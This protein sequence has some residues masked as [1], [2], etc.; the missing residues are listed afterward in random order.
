MLLAN[1]ELAEVATPGAAEPPERLS[2]TM[3][4]AGLKMRLRPR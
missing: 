1:F 2:F 3:T 4:P